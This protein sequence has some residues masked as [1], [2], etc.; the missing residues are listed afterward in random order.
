MI[1]IPERIAQFEKQYGGF[2]PAAR[3]LRID[4][5][6]LWRLKTGDKTN[7]SDAV[8]KKLSLERRISYA[9]TPPEVMKDE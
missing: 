6:Y 8:L 3:A 7:P 4:V 2:R 5:G 1:T 9:P